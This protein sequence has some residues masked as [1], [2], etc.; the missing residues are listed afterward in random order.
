LH[1]CKV[2]VKHADL[3]LEVRLTTTIKELDITHKL[4]MGVDDVRDAL[5]RERLLT[6]AA[7]DVV[8]DFLMCRIRLIEN[9]LERKIRRAKAV[10]EMLSKY[11][12]TVCSQVCQQ[13]N[14]N[15]E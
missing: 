7:L 3:P 1:H 11:P 14:V 5:T 4:G 12:T 13:S 10:A 6:E 8:Q 9:V 2:D 15:G